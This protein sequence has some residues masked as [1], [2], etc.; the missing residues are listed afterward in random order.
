MP[1]E[2]SAVGFCHAVLRHAV[3]ALQI[4]TNYPDALLIFLAFPG[5]KS[6]L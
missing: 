4:R 2:I 5:E 1:P 6:W 3:R